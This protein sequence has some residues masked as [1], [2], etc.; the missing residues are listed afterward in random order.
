MQNNANSPINETNLLHR[1]HLLLE[2]HRAFSNQQGERFNIFSILKM[3]RKEVETHSRFIYEL[4]NPHGRHGMGTTFLELFIADVL[5]LD[6]QRG[7]YTVKREDGTDE[8]RRIDF[9]IESAD[10]MIGI[11][12]KID[13]ADQHNQLYDY[14]LELKKRATNKEVRLYYLTL[15]GAQPSTGSLNSLTDK[16][17]ELIAFSSHIVDWLT[18]CI[19]EAAMK[20]V[21]REALVQYKLLIEKLTGQR[22]EFKME[23]AKQLASN[24][25]DLQAAL[26]IEHAIVKSKIMLQERFWTTLK[27]ALESQEKIVAVYGGKSIKDISENYYQNS[28]GNKNIGLKYPVGQYADMSVYMYINLYSWVHYGLRVC[29]EHGNAVSRR[30]IKNDIAPLLPTGNAVN[31]KKDD[32]ITCYYNDE[33]SSQPIVKFAEFGDAFDTDPVLLSLTN[34]NEVQKLIESIVCHLLKIEEQF[35]KLQKN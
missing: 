23:L 6:N 13:A 16:Q 7:K 31:S 8:G 29:D 35:S 20:P 22:Q 5:S 14:F 12:M 15:F 11:E 17:Y 19:K 1:T 4:L 32:W 24:P 25:N 3:E 9:T 34:E 33:Q 27:Q 26:A 28:K 18:A 21:L 30:D 10:S 2:Q